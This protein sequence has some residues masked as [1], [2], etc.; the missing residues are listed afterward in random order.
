MTKTQTLRERLNSLASAHR[1]DLKDGTYVFGSGNKTSMVLDVSGGSSANG[2]NVQLYQSNDT[3]AQRWR[4]THDSKGYVTLTN[5][6][7]G[8]V[9]DVN[10]ASTEDGANVQQYASN[11]TWAQKW[12]A[13]KNADGSYTFYSGLHDRKVLDVYGGATSNGAN[14]QL[15]AGNGT[16]A[17]RWVI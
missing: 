12:I 2:A 7:S 4:V 10:G 8:K 5:V 9:L 11:G 1:N 13:V 16:K 15:C 3:N 14:V 6:G 17:Q